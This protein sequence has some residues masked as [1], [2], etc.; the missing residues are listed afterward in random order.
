MCEE[1]KPSGVGRCEVVVVACLFFIVAGLAC[2][3]ARDLLWD[4]TES[5][6]RR[7]GIVSERTPEWDTRT[8]I[9]GGVAIVVGIVVLLMVSFG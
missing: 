4:M 7:Q 9:S 1:F 6:H 5:R 3:F 8:Q 2:L